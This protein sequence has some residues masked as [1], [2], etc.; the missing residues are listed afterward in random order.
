MVVAF[1]VYSVRGHGV[2]PKLDYGFASVVE[3]VVLVVAGCL[4][5]SPSKASAPVARRVGSGSLRHR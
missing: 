2:R 5:C 1:D 4:L 3:S